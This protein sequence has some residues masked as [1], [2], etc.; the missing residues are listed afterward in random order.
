MTKSPNTNCSC[1]PF[2]KLPIYLTCNT[3]L[4]T[5]S[6]HLKN[7][8]LVMQHKVSPG[9]MKIDRRFWSFKL[10]QM[11]QISAEEGNV[12]VSHTST[13]RAKFYSEKFATSSGPRLRI[14]HALNV[15]ENTNFSGL[16]KPGH[17]IEEDMFL[18]FFKAQCLSLKV[19][20]NKWTEIP[21]KIMQWVFFAKLHLLRGFEHYNI[22]V[23]FNLFLPP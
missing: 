6:F 9:K 18:E 14:M 21:L 13:Q 23:N 10:M 4:L 3:I 15:W 22:M 5:L 20:K 19:L 11:M 17:I 7:V 1:G 8:T 12:L 2:I 16:W